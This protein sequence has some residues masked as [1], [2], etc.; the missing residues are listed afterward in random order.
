MNIS[1]CSNT[2]PLLM[3]WVI[4]WSTMLFEAK[5]NMRWKPHVSMLY[6]R[7]YEW[8]FSMK[9]FHQFWQIYTVH[10]ANTDYHVKVLKGGW[11]KGL[12]NDAKYFW[13]KST[14]NCLTLAF[15]NHIFA[16]WPWKF[17]YHEIFSW[18]IDIRYHFFNLIFEPDH[19]YN[20]FSCSNTFKNNFCKDWGDFWA[21]WTQ[22]TATTSAD[23]RSKYFENYVQDFLIF[24]ILLV[25]F[26]FFF[27]VLVI[28]LIFFVIILWFFIYFLFL[29]T[30]FFR[31][32]YPS[33]WPT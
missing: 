26:L 27:I 1:L 30:R 33:C 11:F 31:V 18:K 20:Q 16:F 13:W 7:H 8:F 22:K 19:W 24:P 32:L 9:I 5:L 28:F 25:I 23:P 15:I 12:L 4:T 6:C 2:L 21:N 17:W 10:R 29:C 14:Q 3:K